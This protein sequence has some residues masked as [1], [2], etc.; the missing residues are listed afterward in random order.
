VL[1]LRLMVLAPVLFFALL[2]CGAAD[3]ASALSYIGSLRAARTANTVV[4]DTRPAARCETRSVAGARCLPPSALLGPHGRLPA[5]RQLVWVLGTAGLT[6]RETVV[7]AGDDPQRR[8][9]VAGVLFLLGQAQVRVLSPRLTALLNAHRV[10]VGT[11]TGTSMV[12]QPLF[13]GQARAGLIVFRGELLRA[14]RSSHPPVLFD[15][16]S[17]ARYWGKVV[18]ARRGGHIP[19]ARSLPADTLQTRGSSAQRTVDV[20]AGAIAYAQTPASTIAY[21]T[22][23][24]AGLGAP[25]RVFVQG[26]R[27][28]ADHT[29]MPV[30]A[31]T[32]PS[33]FPSATPPPRSAPR[34]G[35]SVSASLFA[36][37]ITSLLFAIAAVAIA[38]RRKQWI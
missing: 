37:S 33:S 29:A 22:R 17:D 31:E 36:V 27:D 12:A 24:T 34:G 38:M 6:G 21:F 30:A 7:V 14:L 4:L 1:P 9:F 3:G 35:T 23:L 2:G 16:R 8:G 25:V 18:T 26:W 13:Q 15:G 32:L 11:G 19:G 28:W 10:P 5:F 20:P